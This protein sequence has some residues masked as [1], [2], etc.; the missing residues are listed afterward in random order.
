MNRSLLSFLLL[1]CGFIAAAQA[2][3]QH[4]LVIYL[5]DG[6][7][8]D[9]VLA[10]QPKITFSGDNLCVTSPTATIEILRVAVKNFKFEK[11]EENENSIEAPHSDINITTQ[12]E[13]ITL[14]GLTNGEII[15]VY[16][17]DGKA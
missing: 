5:N 8:A 14:T 4:K 11:C 15:T 10:E 17:I 1:L 9:F 7:T 6:N 12:K 3:T 13:S 2:E 16:S